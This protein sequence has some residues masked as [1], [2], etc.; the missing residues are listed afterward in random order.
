MIVCSMCHFE[1]QYWNQCYFSAKSNVKKTQIPLENTNIGRKKCVI[2]SIQSKI[3]QPSLSFFCFF[4]CPQFADCLFFFLFS[5]QAKVSYRHRIQINCIF[6]STCKN[7]IVWML[8]NTF[9]ELY[10]PTEPIQTPITSTHTKKHTS[11]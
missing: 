3:I 11:H 7:A 1:F 9:A 4:Q 8:N 5:K 10:I 6:Y 2:I